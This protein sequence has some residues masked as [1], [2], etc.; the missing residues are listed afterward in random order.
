MVRRVKILG[1]DP[2]ESIGFVVVSY[3]LATKQM[4]ILNTGVQKFGE[5]S[6]L[7]ARFFRAQADDSDTYVVENYVIN[8]KVY[9]HDHQGDKGVALRQIGMLEML[10]VEREA[11]VVL[12]MPT[13]K[14][15]GYGFL[16]KQYVRGKKDQHSWDALAHVVFY[17][18][19]KQGMQPLQ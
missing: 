14:P 2:G 10:A 11:T 4:T 12:Q 3:D 17:L 1:V 9:K 18:V 8:P 5:N 7:A 6:A 16:G 13:V 19:T 15:P